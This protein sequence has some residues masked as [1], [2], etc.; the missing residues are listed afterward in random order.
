MR[1]GLSALF[2][3]LL[4]PVPAAAW[5]FE[6]HK[7]IA[8]QFIGLLPP[9]LR[10]LFEKRKTF[11][12]EHAI[13]PDLW[14]TVGW[15]AEPPNHFLDLD[16]YGPAPFVELPREL[17]R[18]IQKFGRDVVVEQGLLPWRTAEFYGKLLRE[19]EGLKRPN[20]AYAV[21]NIVLFS[22]VL[23]HYVGDGFVPLHAV[24]NYDGQLTSQHGVH[25]RWES[26]L[27]E[28]NRSRVK[29]APAPAAPV[30]D[31]REFM[32]Q[33]LIDSSR[34]AE[35]VLQADRRAAQGRE[36]YDDAY[37]DALAKD[38]LGV[39]ET[40]LNGAISAVASIVIGAWE[41]AGRP[42]IPIDRPRTARPI[43]KPGG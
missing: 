37:F 28:R 34:L 22:A 33:T 41:Q 36:F 26:E 9:E 4:Q 32:F 7:A 16:Y 1:I 42:A 15:D 29:M 27:F 25:S 8:E 35:G 5:G 3:F 23:A 19:F 40:R 30:R 18:A 2:F 13:D 20:A 12:V 39:L 14:R 17:D 11:V 10:P 21:D 24:K 6:A 38:Q 31:P 43:R